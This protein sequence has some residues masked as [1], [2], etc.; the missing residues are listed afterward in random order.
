V[1]DESRRPERS[2]SLEA[3]FGWSTPYSLGIEEEFQLVDAETLELVAGIE[4]VLEVFSGEA[5]QRRVK[6]ELLQSV[7]EAS[8]RISVDVEEAVAD[9]TE[10]RGRI[11]RAATDNGALIVAAGTHPLSRYDHQSVTDRP[12]YTDL[13][14]RFGWLIA[15]HMVFG[16]HIHV[17]VSSAAK[18]IACA[19]GLRA[20]VPELL[21]LSA[22][23]PFW[24]GRQT[25]LA[26][27]RALVMRDLPRTG[28]PPTL[29]SYDDFERLV[30]QGVE[31]GCFPDYTYLWWD[32]RPHPRFGTVEV[33]ICDAQTRI[34]NV[35]AIAALVQALTAKLGSDFECGE[36]AATPPDILLEENRWRATRDGLSARLID[37][38]ER[39]ERSAADAIRTLVDLCAPAADA[40]G[41]AEELSLVPQ[42]LARGNGADEQLRVY[43]ESPDLSRVTRWLGD[44]TAPHPRESALL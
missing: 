41:C 31:T 44:Q 17:G 10:L 43:G 26:S 37:L 18:A 42:L 36:P 13:A 21:A 22:N 12:R 35:A 30:E 15:R 3:N 9:L 14:A 19:N 39:T 27:T 40:L 29:A 16:L 4:P 32:I 24:Q 5:L 33:R 20:Y 1:L 28:L 25:G 38:E 34:E 6:P 11:A 2:R 7:V 8:T 23:S